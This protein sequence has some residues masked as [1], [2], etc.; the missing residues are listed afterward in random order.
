MSNGDADDTIRIVRYPNR[1]LYD[2]SHA[3]YV[4]LQEIAD[5]IRQGKSVTIRDSK[6]DEDLTCATL[7]QIILQQHPER[8]ELL[9]APILHGMIRAND[10]VLESLRE[11]F[12]R[13]MQYWDMFQQ[14]ATFNPF[15]GSM[16][17]MKMLSPSS[18]AGTGDQVESLHRRLAELEKR[19]EELTSSAKTALAGRGPLQSD[20]PGGEDTKPVTTANRGEKTKRGKGRRRTGRGS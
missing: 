20:S 1:R 18:A 13:S 12:Q 15:A 11:Y 3:R 2:S 16:D 17:L 5:L 8:M 10:F 6:S 7:M 9:P 4:T 19:I 14:A